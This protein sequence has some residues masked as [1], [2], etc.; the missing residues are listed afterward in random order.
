MGELII[1]TVGPAIGAF[2]GFMGAYLIS[3][4]N[5]VYERKRLGK[6]QFYKLIAL[7]YEIK[8]NIKRC[9]GLLEQR[10][11]KN[12]ISFSTLIAS[13]YKSQWSR[14]NLSSLNIEVYLNIERIYQLFSFVLHNLE[15]SSVI[16]TDV[17]KKKNEET[18]TQRSIIH[19]YRY[20]VA[21]A[22]IREYLRSA[23]KLYNQ[24]YPHVMRYAK[25]NDFN[26]SERVKTDL[27]RY[28]LEYVMD[29]INKFGL[30]DNHLD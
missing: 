23:Y 24:T 27:D 4:L 21:M 18:H 15:K 16:E 7:L 8:G 17:K 2:I 22:F 25:E 12:M 30:K 29:Q 6:E 20:N 28:P 19:E 11:T 5:K 13:T 14:V 3:T 9:E 10:M 26:L 1:L